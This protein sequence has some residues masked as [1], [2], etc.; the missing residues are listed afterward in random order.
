M[1]NLD[2]DENIVI[3]GDMNM[4]LLNNTSSMNTNLINFL[5]DNNLSQRVTEATRIC[6][7]YYE[8][9]NQLICSETLIDV[10]IENQNIIKE[11]ANIMC[12]FSDH[13][14]VMI[15]LDTTPKNEEQKYFT[16]RNL[17][18]KKVD[19]IVVK[20]MHSDFKCM[21]KL[22]TN[23]RWNSL[24][25]AILKIIDEISPEKKI[26]IKND[27]N[28]PWF[29]GELHDAKVLRDR[30][31]R[32]FLSSRSV[33]STTVKLRSS[34]DNQAGSSSMNNGSEFANDPESISNLFNIFFTS[35]SS[36]ST[37]S[38]IESAGFIDKCFTDYVKHKI[39]D[40]FE[41][42]EVSEETVLN[43]IMNLSTSSGP[44]ISGISSKILKAASITLV[45]LITSLFNQCLAENTIPIEWKTAVVTPIYKNK[46]DIDDVNN[47]LGISVLPP[48]AKVF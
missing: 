23:L 24:R 13:M 43:L 22:D 9:T 41:F 29:D 25:A 7:K 27:N 12:P 46:G 4:N 42:K 5:I 8:K 28:Y 36:T 17:S 30:E 39:K 45:P 10:V 40:E 38:H 16:G 2:L 11:V 1:F 19:E 26:Q 44:G 21:D 34:K 6:T 15:T 3:I 37:A 35:L 48:L 47:Y 20:I 32:K 33:D 31:H 18:A 14:F